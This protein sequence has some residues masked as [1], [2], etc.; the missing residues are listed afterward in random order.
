MSTKYFGFY[1]NNQNIDY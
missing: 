1:T